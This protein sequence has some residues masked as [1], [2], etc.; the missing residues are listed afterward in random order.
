M[1]IASLLNKLENIPLSVKDIE[2][3]SGYPCLTF[4]D[5]RSFKTFQGLF[6]THGNKILLIIRSTV[7]SGHYLAIWKKSET[8]IGYFE[9]YGMSLD[10]LLVKSTYS[11]N[12]SNGVNYIQDLAYKSGMSID[13]NTY[14]LQRT[15]TRKEVFATC[16]LHASNRL[17]FSEMNH[18]QYYDFMKS[19]SMI[20]DHLVILLYFHPL[21]KLF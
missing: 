4:E 2:N 12:V 13:Y 19:S 3:I 10:S 8:S 14:K 16:G 9:S 20:P 15:D 21:S 7:S 18:R 11:Y 17:F 5:L 6:E 1:N